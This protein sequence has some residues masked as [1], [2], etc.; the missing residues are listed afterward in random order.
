MATAPREEVTAPTI[1]R[2]EREPSSTTHRAERASRRHG[3]AAAE[4]RAAAG[5]VARPS[6]RQERRRGA[7]GSGAREGVLLGPPV[8]A[9][10]YN[11][12]IT[13]YNN[14]FIARCGSPLSRK[15]RV[16]LRGGRAFDCFR[17]FSVYVGQAKVS[18]AK[19]TNPKLQDHIFRLAI[20]NAIEGQPLSVCV[21]APALFQ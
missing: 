1:T 14:N 9:F 8:E 7:A 17:L 10:V 15:R 20:N 16:G 6:R 2:R 5:A 13:Q 19:K 11:N 4:R 21:S 12:N 18:G 3:R